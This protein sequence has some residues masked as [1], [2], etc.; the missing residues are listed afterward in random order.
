MRLEAIWMRDP[1]LFSIHD[2]AIINKDETVL[3][4][5]QTTP[6]YWIY[7]TTD[8]P[9]EGARNPY[10]EIP[11]KGFDCYCSHD[12]VEWQGP[13][14]AFRRSRDFWAN[15]QFWAPEVYLYRGRIVMLA[16]M[17]KTGKN[18]ERGVVLLEAKVS[19]IDTI[20]KHLFKIL[21]VPKRSFSTGIEAW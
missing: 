5:L 15:T 9:P 3:S 7:G 16:T 20:L 6:P 14:E 19:S 8:R 13:F 4:T 2:S 17:K 11:G 21:S 1:F 18:H 12:L 10:G